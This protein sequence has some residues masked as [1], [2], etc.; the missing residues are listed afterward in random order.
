MKTSTRRF[1]RIREAAFLSRTEV[2]VLA[3]VVGVLV[4]LMVV[5]TSSVGNSAQRAQCL[6]NIKQFDAALLIYAKQNKNRFPSVPN[7]YWA[8]DLPKSVADSLVRGGLTR[9]A[10]YDPG[11]PDQNVD[12]LW[13]WRDGFRIVGYAMTLPGTESAGYTNQNSVIPQPATNSAP[14]A[15]GA[16]GV[17]P[18]QRV[19]IAGPV[20]S[21]FR[22]NDPRQRERYNYTQ[23][24][25]QWNGV[26]RA[27]HLDG[28]GTYPEGDNVGMLDGSAKWRK[29][30]D[31]IPRTNP[32]GSSPIFWW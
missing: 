21:D 31:M 30:Q 18:S 16:S 24:R 12:E 20:I 9:A 3:L 26:H 19:L 13:N 22:Q 7:G 8:W 32:G 17:D 1:A 5:A 28:S 2:I 11:N 14:G 27:S 15:R 23:I 10:M 25:G 6:K 29:F 4:V